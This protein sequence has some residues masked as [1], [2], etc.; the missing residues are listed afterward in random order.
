M[1]LTG[2]S[3][4]LAVRC[5]SNSAHIIALKVI[6]FEGNGVASVFDWPDTK[7]FAVLC[8]ICNEAQ[9]AYGSD[10]VVWLGIADPNF[11]THKA[12]E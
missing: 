3:L 5:Q 12:F 6:E 9:L 2:K 10:V 7:P 8:P 11:K 4:Y 1:D